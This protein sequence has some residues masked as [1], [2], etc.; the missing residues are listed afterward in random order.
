MNSYPISIDTLSSRPHP[1]VPLKQK[2]GRFKRI[3]QRDRLWNFSNYNKLQNDPTG[4][5]ATAI[6]S[7][8]VDPTKYPLR[9]NYTEQLIKTFWLTASPSFREDRERRLRGG[10]RSVE[11]K[12][13]LGLNVHEKVADTTGQTSGPIVA[14]NERGNRVVR[15][16]AAS[17][18]ESRRLQVN[19]SVYD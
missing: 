3:A 18:L 14:S 15:W 12:A 9:S 1:S 11:G 7:L 16:R 10:K 13:R 19:S 4:A 6:P 2:P 5:S 17:Q 8:L